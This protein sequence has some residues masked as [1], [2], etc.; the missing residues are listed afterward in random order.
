MQ[1]RG[2]YEET[3]ERTEEHGV[4]VRGSWQEVIVSNSAFQE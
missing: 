4:Y 1:T 2:Q 3:Q